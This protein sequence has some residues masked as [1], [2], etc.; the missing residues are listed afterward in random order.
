RLDITH[1]AHIGSVVVDP[2]RPFERYQTAFIAGEI[3]LEI[4]DVRESLMPF[5]KRLDIHRSKILVT[6]P[7]VFRDQMA[8]NEAPGD[9]TDDDI[10]GFNHRGFTPGFLGI[11]IKRVGAGD[12][13]L[14][15]VNR[16]LEA[17]G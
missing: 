7:A 10:V 9:A 2:G 15:L 14:S 12:P 17:T 5:R 13:A 6:A 1:A 3:K 4:V 11:G 8:S 16:R